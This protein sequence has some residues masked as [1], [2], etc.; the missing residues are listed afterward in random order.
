LRKFCLQNIERQRFKSENIQLPCGIINLRR[1]IR[2]L[3]AGYRRKSQ[4][5]GRKNRFSVLGESQSQILKSTG[6]VRRTAGC[7]PGVS[8]LG[9]W[10]AYIFLLQFSVPGSQFS[11][12]SKTKAAADDIDGARIVKERN[13]NRRTED[14]VNRR[15]DFDSLKRRRPLGAPLDGLCPELL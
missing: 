11:V 14:R 7:S 9:K 13:G 2:V 1:V 5:T 8:L 15:T 12:K 4:V 3:R 10:K 6:R